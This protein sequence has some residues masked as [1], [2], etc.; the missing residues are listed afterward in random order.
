M[1]EDIFM[2]RKI[3]KKD[4]QQKKTDAV[5]KN[6]LKFVSNTR[7][8]ARKSEMVRP[9]DPKLLSILQQISEEPED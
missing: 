1:I 7:N 3:P 5:T 8:Q 9:S 6:V 4:S 2:E